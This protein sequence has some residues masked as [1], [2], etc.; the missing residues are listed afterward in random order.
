MNNNDMDAVK[1]YFTKDIQQRVNEI[2]MEE[3]KTLLKE[4]EGTPTW[5]AIIKYN[6][7]RLQNAQSGLI[8][9]D[10]FKEPTKMARYQG[11]MSGLLD[12][13]EGVITLRAK[14]AKAEDPKNKEEDS[15]DN[16][17]GAYGVV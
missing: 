11:I 14:A 8:T 15:K 9:L 7:E 13:Q 4:L 17:G 2:S 5:F 6:Q 12:L 16:L 1:T 3:M 10:P